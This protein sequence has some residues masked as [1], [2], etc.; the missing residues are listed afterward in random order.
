MLMRILAVCPTTE[1]SLG[2]V[3]LR[4]S[5]KSLL[6]KKCSIWAWLSCSQCLMSAVR[7]LVWVV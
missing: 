6:F 1:K 4:A 5:L 7:L 3:V 2:I